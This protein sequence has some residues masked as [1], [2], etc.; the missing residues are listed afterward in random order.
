[1]LA[2]KRALDQR[3]RLADIGWTGKQ[4]GNRAALAGIGDRAAGGVERADQRLHLV[5]TL[6]ERRT[7]GRPAAF[8]RR[9]SRL[10]RRRHDHADAALD[11]DA[12]PRLADADPSISPE[13][14]ASATNGGAHDDDLDILVEVAARGG[15]P[16]A[17]HVIVA[18]IAVHD[19]EAQLASRRRLFARRSRRAPGRSRLDVADR[20]SRPAA[21]RVAG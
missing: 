10:R 16:V 3:R 1:M 11:R 6:F 7:G 20:P 21:R 18:G 4:F 14:S 17:Q 12:A 13:P 5:A 2:R 8:R 15:Q 9:G 19:R